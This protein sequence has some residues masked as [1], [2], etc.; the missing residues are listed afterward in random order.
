M[1]VDDDGALADGLLQA[2]KDEGERQDAQVKATTD[3]DRQRPDAPCGHGPFPKRPGRVLVHEIVGGMV[4]RRRRAGHTIQGGFDGKYAGIVGVSVSGQDVQCPGCGRGEA[5]G[6]GSEA[7]RRGLGNNLVGETLE[8]LDFLFECP[9]IQFPQGTMGVGMASQF[10]S[11]LDQIAD[12]LGMLLH[13]FAHHEESG[14][15]SAAGQ[16]V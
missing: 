12:Q 11:G 8:S 14:S 10:M 6:G 1:E 16:Q 4:G 7:A 5:E 9:G 2:A 15:H 3:R 13:H